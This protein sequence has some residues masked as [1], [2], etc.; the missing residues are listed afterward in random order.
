[1]NTT[2][3]DAD[4]ER[5]VSLLRAGGLVAF[6]TETV[7]GLGANARDAEAV[8]KIFAAKGRPSD[9]PLIVHI[10]S[11]QALSQWA[12]RVPESATKLAAA[13]WPG[14]LAMVLPRAAGVP[15]AVTGGLDTVALRVPR[16][17]VAL[18]LLRAFDGG[19]AAP[20]ANRYGR[21]SPTRAAHV[22]EELGDRVDLVLDGGACDV[23]VESTIVDLSGDVPV[24]LR[25]GAVT[26]AMLERVLGTPVRAAG[27]GSTPAPGRK[28][29]HYAP[30][31]KVLLA[32]DAEAVSLARCFQ[33]GGARVGLLSTTAPMEAGID[34]LGLPADPDAQ[35]RELY[36]RLRDADALALDIVV[37]V[38]PPLRDGIGE[39]LHD[40]LRRA[41][42]L[43]D[44]APDASD[45]HA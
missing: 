10:A 22:R 44:G 28:P 29:S 43:G 13:F 32:S 16:H 26:V 18:A 45:L 40:R 42:G 9:H 24:L 33:S 8:S 23:G 4:I 20:S 41:A 35:A 39:A 3:R 7:Y 2:M 25:P 30:R 15:D 34:W 27:E 5:A 37:A 31:A 38:V 12:S 14:P 6:P 1:M 11:A 21:V 19:L 36:Q 17:P